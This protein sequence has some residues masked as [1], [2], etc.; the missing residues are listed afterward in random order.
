MSFNLQTVV[1]ELCSS[2]SHPSIK[3]IVMMLPRVKVSVSRG[4]SFAN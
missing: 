1:T 2:L 4:M 3:K